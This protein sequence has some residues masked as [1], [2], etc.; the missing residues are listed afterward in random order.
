MPETVSKVNKG[1][2]TEKLA[3]IQKELKAPKNQFNKFANF[4]Y[5]SCEDILEGVKPLLG[6]LILTIND[7]VVVIGDRYY[8]KATATITDGKDTISISAFAREAEQKTGMDSAQVT[9]A[10]SSYA[11]KYALNGMFL[12]D[13]NKDADS[14]DNTSKP[15]AAKDKAPVK[16]VAKP[17]A[18]VKKEE[19]ATDPTQVFDGKLPEEPNQGDAFRDEEGNTQTDANGH[20]A[21]IGCGKAVSDKVE[22]YSMKQYKKVLCMQCQI[23]LKTKAKD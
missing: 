21:C 5:R 7:E 12:I 1:T 2:L 11:R 17:T 20:T 22:Q 16:S 18:P 23:K 3:V 10:T 19:P 15:T 14:Q 13:D 4:Y 8:I 6:D 9:G